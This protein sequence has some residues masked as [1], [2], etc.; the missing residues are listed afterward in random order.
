M[1]INKSCLFSGILLTTTAISATF[2]LSPSS[3]ADDTVVDNI[4]VLVPTS[5][6]LSGIGTDS[7]VA[8]INNATYTED[9]G[10][11]TLT[12]FCNDN[13]GF[14][15][16]A[17]G[18]TGDA[19]SGEDHTKLIGTNTNQKIA[20]GTATGTN[21][22]DPSN[23]AMK[24]T[25]VE[26]VSGQE[27]TAYNPA[28]L[29][30]LN[31]YDSY[32]SVPDTYAKVASF[33][34]ATDTTL[35]S[36]LETTYAVFIDRGQ[37]ADTYVGKVKYTLV[38]PA[39]ETPLQPQTTQAGKI[40]Y[41]ANGSNVLGSMG[42]QTVSTSATSAT[43]L[44]S[45]FS[46]EGYGFAGWST[47]FDYSDSTGFYGPQEYI[48]FTAGTYTGQ[49]N[50]L[51][52]YAHWIESAGSLQNWN[53]CSSLQAGA[54]TA[55]TDQRDNETYAV[56]KLADGKCWMIEN[57][58]LENTN[59]TGATNIALAQGYETG[60]TGLAAPEE[61]WT[62]SNTY[63]T[64]NSLYST[65]GSTTNTISGSDLAERFP[66]YSNINTPTTENISDRPSEPTTNSATNPTSNS[67]M[68]SYGNYYTWPATIAN[69]T[70]ITSAGDYNTTSICPKGWSIP[71]GG[72]KSREAT[73]DFWGL[74]VTGLNGGNNPANYASSTAPY[75]TGSAEADPIANIL[76]A[77]PSNFVYSGYIVSG[78]VSSRGSLSYYWSSTTNN[79]AS[80][81]YLNLSNTNAIVRPG[82][83]NSSKY[84]GG[85][86]RCIVPGV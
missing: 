65:D 41:Y 32:S 27:P 64:A 37:H 73:N 50:G 2:L 12:A 49:N 78:S 43:L 79:R 70:N 58:R 5:C 60:F 23:W 61:P 30:I 54:V 62:T 75:Y 14:E 80:A 17:I 44:A 51:S 6:T 83:G 25:K 46:R 20:T 34:S 82:T 24:L 21:N 16:Y 7:H 52:L 18:F 71:R 45:N 1:S 31:G 13:G 74:I 77:Y 38:H 36:K 85:T 33:S 8:T 11:T 72:D 76:R 63:T 15:I 55:L 10:K 39:S 59:T 22:N 84:Y 9:I 26:N 35:G 86:I 29:T 67:G 53:G 28:N 19:Y 48:E 68:Y 66:R 40:C 56:A 47:T 57:M 81:Y 4:S 3:F 69:T 42:C